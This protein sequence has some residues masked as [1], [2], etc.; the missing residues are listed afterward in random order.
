MKTR[1]LMR[2]AALL[3]VATSMMLVSSSCSRETPS[4]R[5]AAAD[6]APVKAA[7]QAPALPRPVPAPGA[8]RP[9]WAHASLPDRGRLLAYAPGEERKSGAYTFYPV[10]FSEANA[11]AAI[12]SGQ[13][14]FETPD[15]RPVTLRYLRHEEHANGNWTWFGEDI[16]HRTAVLTFGPDAVF[17]EL[18]DGQGNDYRL[19]RAQGRPWL[20]QTD[21][22]QIARM[23]TPLT[24]PK[25]SDF[26][27]PP[28][29][30]VVDRRQVEAAAAAQANAVGTPVVDV[31]L[32]YTPGLVNAYGGESATFT[33]LQ[34]LIDITN[35]AYRTSQVN[36]QVRLV[37][38]VPINYADNTDNGD[39][40]E[41][42]TGFSTDTQGSIPVPASLQPLRDA[43]DQYGADLA[44]L[45][46][47][48]NSATNNGCGI[49]WLNGQGQRTI[50]TNSAGFGYSVVSD[51]NGTLNPD[52]GYYCRDETLAHELGH[53]MGS[54]HDR[55]TATTNGN[56]EYG[57]FAYSFG[58]KT[59]A[60]SGNFYTIMAY[61][62][63]GQTKNPVF[64]T[65]RIS[66]CGIDGS[67]PCGVA[68]YADNARSLNN[69]IP[70][71]ANFRA[72]VVPLPVTNRAVN[73]FDGDGKSD[74][75]WWNASSGTFAYWKMDGAAFV[76]GF[77]QGVGTAFAPGA[78]GRTAGFTR[79]DLLF[80]RGS[81]RTL[82]LYLNQGT[83][84]TPQTIGGYGAGWS[85]I[86]RG[87]VDGDGNDEIF[88]REPTQGYFA[89]WRMNGASY[90][91]GETYA[92]PAAYRV[93]AIADL[94]GDGRA[95]VVWEDPVSRYMSVW[96]SE[97]STGFSVTQ[98]GQHGPDWRL[99]G[100]ADVTGDGKADL[101]WRNT[102]N[103]YVAY[104][105]MN[106]PVYV[107]ARAQGT[108]TNYELG[109]LGDYNGDGVTDILWVRSSDRTMF[110]W[111]GNGTQFNE[112]GVGQ[113]GTGWTLL[114]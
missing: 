7:G 105:Q 28:D 30:P 110:M 41:A 31:V 2:S 100:A 93:A 78:T 33:R 34:A 67:L 99:I 51:S 77:N 89:Y 35:A 60:S 50:T 104:W 22:R 87:D 72:T 96:T 16:H 43:R 57:A 15:G 6:A 63:R 9:S 24:R 92:P 103:T 23:D 79:T 46:R 73:D 1:N 98:I 85:A 69:T 44:S 81:D 88:W 106:G 54:Q 11:R 18:P 75:G 14:T 112:F 95:D 47:R 58:Y 68:D 83:S 65:P 48:F 91:G 19:V 45:V 59:D 90:L 27:A 26:F 37:R 8:G 86:G 4:A 76:S 62:D 56:L 49:A 12:G 74:L 61:G 55:V 29:L 5:A 17:G 25:A 21:Q 101:L 20:M 39:A 94:N 40:L 109:T 70:T 80:S 113:Y 32:G 82:F 108:P 107:T 10:D 102:T 97:G 66:I 64:S 114:P 3:A 84:F 38:V 36:A 111:I 42:L 53:N 71:I 13:M 52:G